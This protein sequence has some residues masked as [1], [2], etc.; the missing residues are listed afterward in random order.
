MSYEIAEVQV[1]TCVYIVRIVE[2]L[3]LRSAHYQRYF[4]TTRFKSTGNF[5][6]T[7][8]QKMLKHQWYLTEELG[9]FVII[10]GSKNIQSKTK[11]NIKNI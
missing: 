4:L 8:L 5:T 11:E 10:S 6:I 7:A 9:V 2:F 1:Q 3:K